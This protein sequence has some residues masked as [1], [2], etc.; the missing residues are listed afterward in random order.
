MDAISLH[1]LA[2]KEGQCAGTVRIT[3]LG[4]GEWLGSRLAVRRPFRG[5]VGALLVKK[6]EEE[7]KKRGGRRF[8][9]YIQS[10]RVGFFERCA[11]RSLKRIPDF[12]G[13]PHVLM[14]AAGPIWKEG[15]PTRYSGDGGLD[16]EGS[17]PF[18]AVGPVS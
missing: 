3:P 13:R 18:K 12:H 4:N 17:Q 7:V 1:I 5:R 16:L 6:A 14:L 15:P 2:V 10:S 11:W 9:A 8:R